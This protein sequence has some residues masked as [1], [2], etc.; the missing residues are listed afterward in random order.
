MT[1]VE[2]NTIIAE[3][4]PAMGKDR[5]KQLKKDIR[6]FMEQYP[7]TKYFTLMGQPAKEKE[8]RYVTF[9][10]TSENRKKSVEEIQ[11][12]L[13]DENPEYLG[14]LKGYM[15]GVGYIELWYGKDCYLFFEYQN[16]VIEVGE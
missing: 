7:K 11:S 12:F 4:A 1:E 6:V 15:M 14:A 2:F 16:G 9:F 3:K 8:N 10:V 13:V 5:K